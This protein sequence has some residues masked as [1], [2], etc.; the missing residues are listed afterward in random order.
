MPGSDV[1]RALPRAG[2]RSPTSY[3]VAL[4]DL[5]GVVYV[6]RDAVPGAPE[7][8]AQARAAG[9]AAGLRHQ[10]RRAPA[11]RRSPST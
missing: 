7:A 10:Q 11:G 6:G 9:H 8:L 4:L 3:D 1:L 5:D 2:G